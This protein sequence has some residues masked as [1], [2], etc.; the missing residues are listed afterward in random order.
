[1]LQYKYVDN[2]LERRAPHRVAHLEFAKN[3]RRTQVLAG[4]V[5]DAQAHGALILHRARS[6][7][8]VE[9]FA[10]AD[11]YVQNNLVES[12]SVRCVPSISSA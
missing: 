4:G 7:D 8:D 10:T 12:F 9:A 6:A 2:M 3:W 5:T 1:M 11:P